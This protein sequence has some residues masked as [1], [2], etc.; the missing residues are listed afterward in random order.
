[1]CVTTPNAH[2]GSQACYA[3]LFGMAPAT[4]LT[5]DE[6]ELMHQTPPKRQAHFTPGPD[7]CQ[8]ACRA[9]LAKMSSQRWQTLCLAT[10]IKSGLSSRSPRQWWQLQ[11][12][13]HGFPSPTATQD[14][15]AMSVSPCGVARHGQRCAFLCF[16]SVLR[17]RAANGKSLA[18]KPK[19]CI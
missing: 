12:F 10:P 9:S 8:S 11:Q 3:Q 13:W 4:M 17:V 19:T 15:R 7:A 14:M 6:G 5:G 16:M 18:A 2:C 1:M